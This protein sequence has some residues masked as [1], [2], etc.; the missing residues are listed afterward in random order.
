MNIFKKYGIKEVADVTFYS[1]TRIG[2]KEF[3]T[4]VLYFDT[5]KVSTLNKSVETVNANGGK[6]N[7]KILSWTFDKDLKLKLEDALFSE[8]SMNVFMNGR[9]IADLSDWTSAIA[10]LTVANEYGQKNYS[11]KAFPSPKLTAAE[12]EI[13]FRCA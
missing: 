10:K 1:I 5:L 13:V 7:G 8:T 11:I 12:Q 9:V 2:N 4:P 3:Y 6:A